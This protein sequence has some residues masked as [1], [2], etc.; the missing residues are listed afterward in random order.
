MALM[1]LPSQ[2]IVSDG[3]SGPGRNTLGLLITDR[4]ATTRETRSLVF[5]EGL[6]FPAKDLDYTVQYTL[7]HTNQMAHD[8]EIIV[9]RPTPS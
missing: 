2:L 4:S 9:I 5:P 8:Q 6:V 7:S 3:G 1:N